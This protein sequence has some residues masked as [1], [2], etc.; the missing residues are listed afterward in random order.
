METCMLL[1]FHVHM[2]RKTCM[3]PCN[4]SIQC[5][6]LT[7]LERVHRHVAG[8]QQQQ[9]YIFHQITQLVQQSQTL[10]VVVCAA[11][12]IVQ[13]QPF[14]GLL[15]FCISCT[16]ELHMLTLYMWPNGLKKQ[17]NNNNKK[18][19][20]YSVRVA[21]SIHAQTTLFFFFFFFG[22]FFSSSLTIHAAYMY[23][24]AHRTQS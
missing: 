1:C 6:P 21:G 19:L 24:Y 13:I 12:L 9:Q 23:I 5:S 10:Y 14:V 17:N 2:H 20:T 4:F 11:S 18:R 7:P 22:I 3:L 8:V 15:I 16:Y